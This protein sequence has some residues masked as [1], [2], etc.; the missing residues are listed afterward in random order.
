MPKDA[1]HL[2]AAIDVDEEDRCAAE[3]PPTRP[4]AATT[5]GPRKHAHAVLGGIPRETATTGTKPKPRRARLVETAQVEAA[6][7]L[8]QRD[9]LGGKN[10]PAG[11]FA[12]IHDGCRAV[13]DATLQHLQPP[14]DHKHPQTK[15]SAATARVPPLAGARA[16]MTA[17]AGLLAKGCDVT[18]VLGTRRREIGHVGARR[19]GL[20]PLLDDVSK[21]RPRSPSRVLEEEERTGES[22]VSSG[23]AGAAHG[24][25]TTPLDVVTSVG[26]EGYRQIGDAA[27]AS[28]S[29]GS[30]GVDKLFSPSEL[31]QLDARL[32]AL[33]VKLPLVT[34]G[35]ESSPRRALPSSSR[36]A[37][38]GS[39]GPL[40]AAWCHLDAASWSARLCTRLGL[41]VSRRWATS[42]DAALDK[43]PAPMLR[44]ASFFGKSDAS[45]TVAVGCGPFHPPSSSEGRKA[46][47]SE[48]R[49]VARP[50]AAAIGVDVVAVD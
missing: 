33:I 40:F 3:K 8:L 10:Q 44:P 11:W 13:D 29:E 4:A 32:T 42:T 16:L 14:A 5:L 17:A 21:R 49:A 41:H 27:I 46:A 34:L 50:D 2:G 18:L 1:Q 9:C 38:G 24:S 22:A 20:P 26:L 37:G 45:A 28:A 23:G 47:R 6:A 19:C 15:A 35:L 12:T 30:V 31:E 25:R 39:H 43:F 48:A 7:M 36:S